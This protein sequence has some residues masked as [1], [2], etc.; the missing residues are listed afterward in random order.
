LNSRRSD[1]AFVKG[2]RRWGVGRYVGSKWLGGRKNANWG[3]KDSEGGRQ[4]LEKG[5]APF[6][7]GIGGQKKIKLSGGCGEG[8]ANVTF[9]NARELRYWG[10]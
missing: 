5:I 4:R 9:K 7:I 10:S 3:E 8:R 2:S 6:R 1:L